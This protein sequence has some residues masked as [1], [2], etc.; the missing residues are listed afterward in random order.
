MDH[1]SHTASRSP[2][3]TFSLDRGPRWKTFELILTVERATESNIIDWCGRECVLEPGECA[4]VPAEYRSTQ[5]LR[6][7]R[8]SLSRWFPTPRS[9]VR[10]AG[11]ERRQSGCPATIRPGIRTSPPY[12]MHRFVTE[13]NRTGWR[14]P[15]GLPQPNPRT[16]LALVSCFGTDMASQFRVPHHTLEVGCRCPPYT[17]FIPLPNLSFC[18]LGKRVSPQSSRSSYRSMSRFVEGA[19]STQV[20]RGTWSSSFTMLSAPSQGRGHFAHGSCQ[21]GTR[22]ND[23]GHRKLLFCSLPSNPLLF[24]GSHSLSRHTHPGT[25]TGVSIMDIGIYTSTAPTSLIPGL[26]CIVMDGIRDT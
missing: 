1:D 11:L 6:S 18:K 24:A 5:G 9:C 3:Q 23:I 14:P 26:L 17:R 13:T 15:C 4:S 8:R 2:F 7:S 16:G 22:N 21:G 19:S 25:G 10:T 20:W 12:P